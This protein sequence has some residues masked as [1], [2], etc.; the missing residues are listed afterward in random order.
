M[1]NLNIEEKL[2]TST[3]ELARCA[4]IKTQPLHVLYKASSGENVLPDDTSDFAV[5]EKPYTL[6]E[7]EK[8]YWFSAE[9]DIAQTDE[10]TKAYLSVETFIYGVACTIRPQGL[11]YLNG[12]VV[13]GIDINHTEVYLKPGHYKMLLHFYTHTFERA[14]PVYFSVKYKDERTQSLFYD[15]RVPFE[16]MRSLPKNDNNYSTMSAVLE[17]AINLVD[18]RNPHSDAFYASVE[19]A[20]DYLHRHF[21]NGVCGSNET[22]NC[23]G[24]THIDVAW[25]W[26]LEQ[27]RQKVERSFSTVLK[28]M[29][30]YPEYK[31]MSS[32]PQL[33]LYLKERN[34]DL[35]EKIK[36]KVKEG[37]WEIEGSSWLEADCNLTGGESLVRQVLY[38][39]KFF[40]DEFG[41][42][43]K[44][45]WE[46][47]AFGFNGAL[48]QIMKKSGIEK[49][50]TAKIGLN[51]T[52]RMPY[53]TFIWKG[54]DGSE[55]FTHMISTCDCNPRMGIY[56]NGETTYVANLTP[57][58][59]LGT[60]NRYQ[61]KEF[62]HTTMMTYGWGDGGG[63]PT[64][65]MLERQRRFAYGI[66]GFPKTKISTV[67][68]TLAEIEHNFTESAAEFKRLPTW[69]GEIYFEYH[70]GTYT[71]VPKN[72]KNNRLGE[73][74]MFG[75]ELYSVMA[76]QLADTKY[77]QK[78]LFENWK[79]LLLNQFHDILPGSAIKEV[80][81][82]SDEQYNRLFAETD[83]IRQNALSNIAANIKTQ[84][85]LAVFNP[86]GFACDGT[87]NVDGQTK[88]VKNVPPLG[89]KVFEALPDGDAV[90]V[91]EHGIENF[92]YVLKFSEDGGIVSLFDKENGRELCQPGEK[93]NRLVAYE[94][95][96]FQYDNW[97][98]APYYKQKSWELCAP[99]V[100]EVIADGDRAGLC[101]TRHYGN[102]VITQK[103]YLYAHSIRRIDVV[104]NISWKEKKQLLK[105]HFPL[106]LL[107]NKATFDIQFGNVERST[108]ANA[109]WDS[110]KFESP[111]HKWVDCSENNYGFALL[112][113]GKYGFAAA[114]NNLS[115]TLLKSGSFPYDGASDDI[116]EFTYSLLPHVGDF[117]QGGVMQNAYVLNRPLCAVTVP[118]Q[119]GAL[120]D[121]YSFI[122][123]STDGVFV[124]AV[125]KSEDGTAAV[126]RL[127]EAYCETKPVTLQFGFDVKSVAL[128]DLTEREES[129]LSVENNRVTFGIKP[130][131]IVTLKVLT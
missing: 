45:F 39:K 9:F 76:E 118:K 63:G 62:N 89:Y 4:V 5:F 58:H 116:P 8:Y 91:S 115:V 75:S 23:I 81:D 106:N 83:K 74:A 85:G 119:D 73:A 1:L 18:F 88:I 50:V 97:E 72:K 66:P 124:E 21:Y 103:I 15:F 24:H 128:C 40:K 82:E 79:L 33:Y 41:V 108:T 69:N 101:I 12:E 20:K 53:D 38:G 61:P 112:N 43:C 32:Q 10:N 99:A 19:A 35:Y 98:I 29:E 102:S 7:T 14:L 126:I 96:P 80:Y 31:F 67:G 113:D 84:G 131:E 64:S 68:E 36:Q 46:P 127:Y 110:A 95:M 71:S 28:L 117:R 3:D 49:F 90:T 78:E 54:I 104:T 17:K 44:I 13:Q 16:C 130:F 51:D 47:D 109:G 34:P 55:I 125:K 87:L 129:V 86:N 77:P 123:C 70:R 26:T 27:T 100:F 59:V 56:D 93:L 92:V 48:P 120:S 52:N 122:D 105:A 22:V 25:M 37:R 94:D 11:L 42:D 65:D 111:A 30:E 2:S 121:N 107:F 6:F 114:D 57:S 60:W